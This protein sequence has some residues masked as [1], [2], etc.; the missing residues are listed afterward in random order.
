MLTD[1]CRDSEPFKYP[2]WV[3]A[4]RI[5]LLMSAGMRGIAL[6][7]N[8]GKSVARQPAGDRLRAGG[9]RTSV[10][11]AL[12]DLVAGAGNRTRR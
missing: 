8:D 2:S 1:T 6:R 3:I 9:R 11:H 10:A 4:A 5:N 7:Q 12:N